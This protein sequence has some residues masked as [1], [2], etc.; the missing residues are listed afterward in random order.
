MGKHQGVTVSRC[1]THVFHRDD[2]A[3]TRPVVN[4]YR[5]APYRCEL[6]G[7]HSRR[8]VGCATGR[9]WDHDS[10]RLIGP[11]L[12]IRGAAR[13]LNLA[14]PALTRSLR[15][16]EQALS[17]SLV[18]RHARGVVL[19]STGE[20]FLVRARSVLMV[21]QRGIDEVRFAPGSPES[22]EGSV[23][24]VL[25]SAPILGQ[26]PLAY[27]TFRRRCPRVRLSIAEAAF[28][29]AEPMLRNGS[30]D[31]YVG[32]RPDVPL[33]GSYQADM[34]YR[35]ERLIFARRDHPLRGANSLVQLQHS[36]WLYNGLRTRA[37]QDLADLF[38]AHGLTPP[39]LLTRLQSLLATLALLCAS[40]AVASLPK[41]WS[42]GSPLHAAICVIPIKEPLSG[43]DIVLIHKAGLPLTPAAELLANLF[44]V[45]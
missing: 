20:R 38:T 2:A 26:L 37:E 22:L 21:M 8:N 16:L 10:N 42:L 32:P 35:N 5:L 23:S 18:E 19:T 28:P 31:F 25:S 24:V 3:G 43:P 17:A 39:V 14:Q 4:L 29:T 36:E 40:D 34:L 6:F 13:A 1:A 15:D 9:S 33:A 44:R 30:C 7:D 41:Q 11:G 45:N 27:R 12:G